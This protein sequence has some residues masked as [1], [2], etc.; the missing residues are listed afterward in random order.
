MFAFATGD[1]VAAGGAIPGVAV[2]LA[3]AADPDASWFLSRQ[4]TGGAVGV[5][6]RGAPTGCVSFRTVTAE[7]ATT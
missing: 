4:V 5:T 1:L 3:E 6:C 7:D 2:S